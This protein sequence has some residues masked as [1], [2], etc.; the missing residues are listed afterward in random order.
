MGGLKGAVRT[1][2][3]SPA[4]AVERLRWTFTRMR[5]RRISQR[6]RTRRATRDWTRDGRATDAQLMAIMTAGFVEVAK[7]SNV[8]PQDRATA[9]DGQLHEALCRPASSVCGQIGRD[10]RSGV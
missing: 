5:L 8:R 4:R 1:G 2:T 9:G 3:L 7:E 10:H 6:D